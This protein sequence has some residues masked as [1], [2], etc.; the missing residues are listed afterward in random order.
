MNFVFRRDKPNHFSTL[1]AVAAL[2]CILLFWLPVQTAAQQD[3]PPGVSIQLEA[4][5]KK[6]TVGDPIQLDLDITTP[7][8]YRAEILQPEMQTGDFSILSFSA[9][10]AATGP[11]GTLQHH[12]AKIVAAAY[13]TGTFAFPPVRIIL[14]DGEGKKTQVLSPSAGIEIQSV[15][16]KDKDL[17]DLKKQSDMPD[18]FR[19]LLWL[20]I[21]LAVGILALLA[22]RIIRRKKSSSQVAP[23]VPARDPLDAAESDLRS[24][25][26]QGLPASGR[27]KKFYILL[28]DIVKRILEAGFGISTVER[29]TSEIME[30]LRL[31][32]SMSSEKSELIESFLVA[33]DVVKFAK[34]IPSRSEH[35]AAAGNAQKILATARSSKLS[36]VSLQPSADMQ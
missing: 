12:R 34:Y 15:I 30:L 7:P 4:T 29:T 23:K 16:G 27:E 33:C 32:P 26:D 2:G 36:A 8:A 17:K 25:L 10:P 22:W 3:L 9:Q 21:A 18:P 24:L 14:M 5:P 13:K 6:A 19:W 1:P 31:V 20:V 35:E 11:K 28:S